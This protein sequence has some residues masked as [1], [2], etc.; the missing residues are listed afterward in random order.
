MKKK[1]VT[2]IAVFGFAITSFAQNFQ[3]M[4][5]YESKTTIS[6][7]KME[8]RDITPEMQ[9]MIQER[10][11]KMLEKTF[12]LNF[13]RSTSIYKEEEKLDAPGQQ[14]PGSRMMNSMMGSGGTF[15]KNVK[16]KSYTVD[17]EFMGKEFLIV[18]SLPKLNWKLE[19][20]TKKI[21]DY[22]CFKATAVKPVSQS[23]FRNFRRKKE[24][25][26]S[27]EAKKEKTTNFME[28]FEMPKEVTITAW[29]TPD[30][31]VNQGPESYWGLPGLIL[32]VN[33]GKTVIVCS[34]VV[35][36]AKDKVEIKASKNGKVVKQKEYDD[37]VVKKMEEM[38]EMSKGQQGGNRMQMRMGR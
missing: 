26:K 16:E 20:E 19:S 22:N 25:T 9:K 32:E 15:F 29:Y 27:D 2:A 28:D 35:L 12:A 36:N 37:I 18:D 4:A 23:D 34:K 38:R 11:K 24:D 6:D 10:M 33:D 21:G 3:G 8:G 30:V 5:V 7:F 13:D 14:G 1:I 17:K 31:P